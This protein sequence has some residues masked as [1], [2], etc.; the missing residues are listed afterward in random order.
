MSFWLA[1]TFPVVLQ[2]DTLVKTT[3]LVAEVNNEICS[4]TIE[5]CSLDNEIRTYSTTQNLV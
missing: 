5:L 1:I 3:I 2:C 4:L